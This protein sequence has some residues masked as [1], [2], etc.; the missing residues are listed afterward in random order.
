M[1][2]VTETS[3]Q[4]HAAPGFSKSKLWRYHTLTPY[5]AEFGKITPKP[6]F[7]IGHAAHT[8][9]LEP[10]LLES[11]VYKASAKRRSGEE[12]KADLEEA[13]GRICLKADDYDLAMMIRDAA[14]TVEELQLIRKGALIERSCYAEDEEHGVTV[15]CRPDVCNPSLGIMGDIKNMADI[16]DRAW[17]RD[18]GAWGYH[19]QDAMYRDVWNRGS[20]T[21]PI[22]AFFFICFSKTEPVEVICRE[23]EPVDVEE[24]YAA[25]RAALAIAAD[26]HKR[27]EWP[28]QP[29][30]V[31]R[32]VKMRDRDRRYTEPQ[33]RRDAEPEESE[34]VAD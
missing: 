32:G 16:S 18:I 22:E 20:G 29:K 34:Y 25:Y 30:G 6:Q 11:T 14:D 4:Y 5:R 26:C 15:K 31:V 13:N 27:Q 2:L 33:W 28:G 23:L 17:E 3:D 24:G 7:D 1:P 9:I 8:A 21:D 19:V 10:E 12:W